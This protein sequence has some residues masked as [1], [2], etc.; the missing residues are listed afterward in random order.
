[1]IDQNFAETDAKWGPD[2]KLLYKAQQ[3]HMSTVLERIIQTSD[4]KRFNRKNKTDPKEVWRLHELHQHLSATNSTITFALSQELAKMKVSDFTSSTIFLD[5]FDSKLEQFNKLS[6]GNP[7]PEKM[8]IGF[9]LSASHGNSELRNAWA[10]KWTICQSAATPTVPTYSEY[11]DY[12]MFHSKQL[13]A[14]IVNNRSTWQANSSATDYLSQYSPSDPDYQQASDL[15]DYM[16]VQDIDFIQHTLECNRAFNEGRPRP[17][18]RTRR[19]PVREDLKI[20][21]AW[22][23]MTKEHKRE[24]IRAKNSTKDK[25]KAQFSTN[26]KSSPITKNHQLGTDGRTVYLVKHKDDIGEGYYSDYTAN[27]EAT[28]DFNANSTVYDTDNNSNGESVI[29]EKELNVNAAATQQQSQH[30]VVFWK[31]EEEAQEGEDC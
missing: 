28:F 9:L 21:D 3:N 19:E 7:L 13:E 12:L 15:S 29:E 1:M 25:I 10:T 24:W 2:D 27:F 20:K 23:K 11:F 17:E 31:S 18:Q 6:T 8:A 14:S 16:D 30:Q 5:E 26:S 22:P 4:G